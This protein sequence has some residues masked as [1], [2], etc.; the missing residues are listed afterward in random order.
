MKFFRAF[1]LAISLALVATYSAAQEFRLLS[2]WDK[3]YPYNPAIL[4]PFMKGVT[5]AS[6]G[7]MKFVVSGPETVPPFEQLQPV[8]SGVFQFLFTSGAYHFG[9]TPLLTAVEG[10][11][12]NLAA[13]RKAGLI[14]Y[15]DKHYQ[16]YGVKI[17][18]L[19]IT[20]W[21]A[22]HIILRQPIG[23]SGDL[24]GRKIRGTPSHAPIIKTLGGSMV[25]L[26]PSEIYT[27]LD[28]GI[29]DGAAWPR[30][31]ALDYRWYEVSKHLVRP[32]YGINYEP[33]F[34]NLKAWNK[35]P[36]ADRQILLQVA[37]TVEDSWE[38]ESK[39]LWEKEEKA[40]IAKGMTVTEV[41]AAQKANMQ[42][43]LS[44]GLWELAVSKNPKEV[45]DL[46]QFARS[47]GLT[48]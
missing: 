11:N 28:K 33:I 23:G 48:K 16:K 29:V 42:A 15:L 17:I 24:Q 47:K 40:L 10:M 21:G 22:Y 26:P 13:I 2:S 37:R 36:E 45:E 32:G 41:G 20:T 14:D 31:G 44:E 1:A 12:T 7:R 25:T 39:V 34:M 30:I 43:A 27:G 46:R 38:K 9:T 4:E 8:G 3:N 19:P 5:E 35:L 6:K 18:A